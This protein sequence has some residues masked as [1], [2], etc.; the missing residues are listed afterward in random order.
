MSLD[1]C[2]SVRTSPLCASL[3]IPAPLSVSISRPPP[4][5]TSPVSSIR[6]EST[7]TRRRASPTASVTDLAR[8]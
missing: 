2:E 8:R 6:P 7:S 3:R 5:S 1:A 4:P